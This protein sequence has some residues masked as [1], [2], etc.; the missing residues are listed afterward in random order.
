MCVRGLYLWVLEIGIYGSQK[1]A[2]TRLRVGDVNERDD[3]VMER[4]RQKR[5]CL[6]RIFICRS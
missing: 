3:S 1:T 2:V 4:E 6:Y 5:R